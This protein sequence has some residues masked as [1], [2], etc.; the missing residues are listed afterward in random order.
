MVVGGFSDG[1]RGLSW[2]KASRGADASPSVGVFRMDSTMSDV[3]TSCTSSF[4]SDAAAGGLSLGTI[5]GDASVSASAVALVFCVVRI[6]SPGSAGACGIGDSASSTKS[7]MADA[8]TGG[9]AISGVRMRSGAGA[10]GG[11]GGGVGITA[12]AY[13]DGGAAAGRGTD[14]GGGVSTC[15]STGAGLDGASLGGGDE[16]GFGATGGGGDDGAFTKAAG[17]G[18]ESGLGATGGGGDDGAFTR[19]GAGPDAGAAGATPRDDGGGGGLAAVDPKGDRATGATGEGAP[20]VGGIDNGLG[21]VGL[22]DAKSGLFPTSSM[23]PPAPLSASSSNSAACFIMVRSSGGGISSSDC[24][25]GKNPPD[26]AGPAAGLLADAAAPPAAAELETPAAGRG[27]GG[28]PAAGLGEPE[29][30]VSGCND[31]MPMIVDLPGR[32]D[33][34][35]GDTAPGPVFSRSAASGSLSSDVNAEPA[36]SFAPTN[37]SITARE[38]SSI[39]MNFT[40]M[41]P[42]RSGLA[43]EGSRFHTTRPTPAITA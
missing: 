12:G 16:S 40:P 23:D 30:A 37:L 22:L 2:E 10:D 20:L 3:G 33:A 36:S 43:C 14:G 8:D 34:P 35:V 18:D 38:F 42:G 1:I 26:F 7:L 9:G 11:G 5:P 41:P 15:G 28:F 27:S 31:P 25:A 24:V 17:G 6:D 32:C 29:L 21:A 19:I 39:L 4:C 13:G